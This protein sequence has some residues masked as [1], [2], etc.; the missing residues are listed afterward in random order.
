MIETILAA[1]VLGTC[2]VIAVRIEVLAKKVLREVLSAV[3]ESHQNL[4]TGISSVVKT[5]SNEANDIKQKVEVRVHAD[6]IRME[7]AVCSECSRVVVKFKRDEQGV[8]RC[9][10]CLARK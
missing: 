8:I 9:L 4:S 2:T 1:V 3:A 6:A 5:L 7:R 10:D